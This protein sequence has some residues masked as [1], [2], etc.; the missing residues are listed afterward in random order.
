MVDL[1][2]KKLGFSY[3]PVNCHIRYSYKNGKWDEGRLFEKDTIELPVSA[4]CL[5]YGQACFEG[6]KA[7]CCKD[8][9]IRIFRP[10]QNSKRLNKTLDHI[11]APEVP[12]EMFIDAIMKV[13]RENIEYVPPY[14]TGGSLY[15]RPLVIGSSAQIGVNSSDEFDFIVLVVPVGPYY[16]GGIKPV[17]ALIVEDLDRAAPLGT[18]HIKVAGNYTAGLKPHKMAKKKGYEITL[19][20]DSKTRTY[21][22]EFGTSNFIGITKDG[23]YVT[24]ESP[25]I[26]ESITNDSLMRIA[27]DMGI[28]VE[29]RPIHIDELED[30]VEVGACGTA[31]VITPVGS[32]AMNGKVYEY[33]KELG[34]VLRKLYDKVTGIQYG[35]IPDS[36]NWLLEV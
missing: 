6:L 12:E 23:R 20:L 29:R 16:K 17:D 21:I 13:I 35:E 7:F 2:W 10:D 18:G 22:E 19:F 3:I 27:E 31:V 14:G 30:F 1:D 26:L 15:I 28:T 11:L 9:K 5:H 33:G 25:S 24:P 34:P 32:I 36:H 8:G 4:V